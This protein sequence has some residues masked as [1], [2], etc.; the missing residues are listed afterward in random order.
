MLV[1]STGDD[2][3]LVLITYCCYAASPGLL[4]MQAD[5]G[6]SRQLSDTVT[7]AN[8]FVGSP[9]WM[10]PEVMLQE[11]YDSKADVWSLGQFC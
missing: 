7:K 11:A 2:A 1:A 8:T 9:Y 4:V 5:F 6:T 3:A 10:A